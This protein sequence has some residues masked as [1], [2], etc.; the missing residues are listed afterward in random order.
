M[1]GWII[2]IGWKQ[3]LIFQAVSLLLPTAAAFNVRNPTRN[4]K[5][6]Q[7]FKI[8]FLS[9]HNYT[10]RGFVEYRHNKF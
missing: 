10:S 9:L 4:R 7:K 3:N 1:E 8:I 2:E 6:V 5:I